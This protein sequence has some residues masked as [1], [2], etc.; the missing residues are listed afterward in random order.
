VRTRSLLRRAVSRSAQALSVRWQ[1]TNFPEYAQ[2]ALIAG[3]GFSEAA[4]MVLGVPQAVPQASGHRLPRTGRELC[5][6]LAGCAA[7]FLQHSCSGRAGPRLLPSKWGSAAPGTCRSI[8]MDPVGRRM[9][10][11]G[12]SR[13]L[14]EGA[15]RR[16][17]R[18]RARQHRP[19]T[20]PGDGRGRSRCLRRR[21]S[22]AILRK[23]PCIWYQLPSGYTSPWAGP[24]Q[25]QSRTHDS[26]RGF[27][28]RHT[29]LPRSA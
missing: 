2:R 25:R 10:L 5:C 29:P 17:A 13:D 1:V 28:A 4:P 24:W 3:G 22:A 23:D 7:T 9:K 26:N 20:D 27:S 8:R 16:P 14:H 15:Q 18:Q 12:A 11:S 19:P 6:E 21:L